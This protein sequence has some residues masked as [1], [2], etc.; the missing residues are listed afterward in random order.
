VRTNESGH[1]IADVFYTGPVELKTAW[2][3]VGLVGTLT[4]F[5]IHKTILLNEPEKDGCR[6]SA[7][8]GL[9]TDVVKEIGPQVGIITFLLLWPGQYVK[10]LE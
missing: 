1:L 10:I 5:P 4:P 7:N 9:L 3:S 6:G 8:L 2:V